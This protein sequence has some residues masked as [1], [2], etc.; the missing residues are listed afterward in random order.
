VLSSCPVEVSKRFGW[1]KSGRFLRLVSAVTAGLVL[2][3]IIFNAV[4]V[5]R[6]PPTFKIHVSSAVTASGQAPRLTSIDVD[7]SE[8]VIPDTAEKAFSITPN[9]AGSFHWQGQTMIFTPSA[10]LPLSTKFQVRIGPGVQDVA[11]NSQGAPSEMNF[12]TVGAPVVTS[13]SPLSGADSVGVDGA[14]VITFDRFMDLQ[15]VV[16]GL[17][18]KPE[19]N[20]QV[21]WNQSTLTLTPTKPLE[22]GTAYTVTIGDPAVDTDGTKLDPYALTFKTVDMGLRVSTLIPTPNV[23]GVSIHS[24]VAVI[25]DAPIDPASI[26]GAIK[27]TPPV[28]GSMKVLALP[29]D[30]KPSATPSSSP[31]AGPSASGLGSGPRVLVFT[32]DNPLASH[33]TYAVTMASSV[34]KADGEAAAGQSWSFTTGEAAAN[35]LNQIAFVSDRAGVDNV[36]LMNPDGSNQREITAEL[37]PVG[38]FDVS[39]DGTSISYS[40][41]G[42]VKKMSVAGDNPQTLTTPGNY[43]YAPVFTLDGTGL[44][45]GRRDSH[46]ADAGYWRYPLVSGQDSRQVAESG[47]PGLGSVTLGADGLTG[48]SGVPAWFGRAAFTPDGSTMLIVR[49]VDNV[50]EIV[51]LTGVNKPITLN[52]SGNARPVWA[53]AKGLFYV[54]ATDDN[55]LT[56]SLWTITAAGV[57]TK[58]GPSTSDIATTA[59]SA[60]IPGASAS[61]APSATAAAP[62]DLA[63]LVKGTDGS[64]HL[65]LLGGTG[66]TPL[67]LTTETSFSETSPSFSPDGSTLVFGRVSALT[68]GGSAGIWLVKADGSELTNL[69]VDGAYPRWL[70]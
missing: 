10:K 33:T 65:E 39:G 41:G 24:Q 26:S 64:I 13:V 7:F 67:V 2:C 66:T 1:L 5:D 11:G 4:F 22:F 46:G 69:S 9:V 47:A 31:S 61:P 68:P 51:D 50:V 53:A 43:E 27:L 32:P 40:A 52:I 63:V 12:T 23:A 6:I 58:Q 54:T 28:S 21:S 37:V 42:I 8:K 55:G 48:Q 15:K 17:S 19:F 36:W 57:A 30:R 60:T 29:D 70:P 25:F 14:I 20:Y 18:V 44:I 3:A 45:V 59:A 16:A 34:K 38:G 49:G 62:K 56:W 35:A